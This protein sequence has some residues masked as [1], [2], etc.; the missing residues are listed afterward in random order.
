MR[1]YSLVSHIIR[2]V[3]VPLRLY[4]V[5]IQV[6]PDHI[7]SR[8]KPAVSGFLSYIRISDNLLDPELSGPAALVNVAQRVG[9]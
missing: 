4:P 6:D 5:Y 3:T 2:I 9:V 7:S 1:L 8:S